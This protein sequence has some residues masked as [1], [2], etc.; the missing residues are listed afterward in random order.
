M[1]E[2]NLGV[3]MLSAHTIVG[4]LPLVLIICSDEKIETHVLAF[5]MYKSMFS[6][7][8][9]FHNRRRRPDVIL[10][11][12]CGE[13]RDALSSNWP[14]STLLLCI[15]H[16]LNKFGIGFMTPTI[17]SVKSIDL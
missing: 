15:I 8:S 14:S 13:L 5:N 7:R 1:E 4:T 12:H 11:D 10:T 3:F 16:F 9:I 17:E 2:H 6:R